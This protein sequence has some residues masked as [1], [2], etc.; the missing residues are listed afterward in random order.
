LLDETLTL[1]KLLSAGLI[2]T[3]VFLANYKSKGK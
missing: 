3:G 1:T 2:M